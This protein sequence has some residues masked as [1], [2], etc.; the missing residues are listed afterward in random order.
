MLFL[1]IL[2]HARTTK[3]DINITVL[4]SSGYPIPAITVKLTKENVSIK[5][6]SN[7]KGRISFRVPPGRYMLGQ[8]DASALPLK[9]SFVS[10]QGG[11][12]ISLI[13]RPIQYLGY[14]NPKFYASPFHHAYI[15]RH[16]ELDS[17]SFLLTFYTQ[18]SDNKVVYFSGYKDSTT[19][20]RARLCRNMFC[21][22]ADSIDFNW[23]GRS[24]SAS[25]RV[26][27]DIEGSSYRPEQA[28]LVADDDGVHLIMDS[29][30]PIVLR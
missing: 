25:G 14:P 7:N 15:L 1:P 2:L 4:D 26:I 20:I 29:G 24:V 8:G 18:V 27:V 28:R 17:I 10:V 30:D 16:K 13:I 9:Y 5:G 12:R 23:N 21:V 11:E 6:D 22:H 3:G 19:S